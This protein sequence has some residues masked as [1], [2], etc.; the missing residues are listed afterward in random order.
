MINQTPIPDSRLWN[1]AATEAHIAISELGP[2][3]GRRVGFAIYEVLESGQIVEKF[4]VDASADP[5][6]TLPYHLFFG[7]GYVVTAASGVVQ[8][9]SIDED[10]SLTLVLSQLGFGNCFK[11]TSKVATLF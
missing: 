1:I 4:F 8:V 6:R 5:E 9:Y 3:S 10:S 11:K 7:S 2:P